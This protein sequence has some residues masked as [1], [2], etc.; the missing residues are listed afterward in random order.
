MNNSSDSFAV[1]VPRQEFTGWLLSLAAYAQAGISG[2]E[3]IFQAG[4]M[5]LKSHWGETRM[6]Y[7]GEFNGTVTIKPRSILTLANKGA[8]MMPQPIPVKLTIDAGRQLLVVDL[9]EVNADIQVSALTSPKAEA[10]NLRA[11]CVGITIAAGLLVKLIHEAFPGKPGKKEVIKFMA[12]GDGLIVQSSRALAQREA[13]I[14]G[15]GEWT[16]SSQVFR[17]VLDTYKANEMLTMEV[18]ARGLK[19]NSFSMPV[20]SWREIAV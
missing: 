15:G 18:D 17:K 5:L 4:Q 13:F 6:P 12:K 20:L 19:L 7:E 8:K 14:M 2:V 11:S 10:P 1:T 9:V 16:V 3:F